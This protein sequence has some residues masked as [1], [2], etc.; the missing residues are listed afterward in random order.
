MDDEVETEELTYGDILQR[1]SEYQESETGLTEEVFAQ[2]ATLA[3]QVLTPEEIGAGFT[4][5]LANYAQDESWLKYLSADTDDEPPPSSGIE[6][7]G[8]DSDTSPEPVPVAQAAEEDYGKEVEPPTPKLAEADIKVPQEPKKVRLRYRAWDPVTRQFIEKDGGERILV[9]TGCQNP[10]R[11]SPYAVG[12][13]L[14]SALPRDKTEQANLFAAYQKAGLMH[15]GAMI[16]RMDEGVNKAEV[17]EGLREDTALVAAWTQAL[18]GQKE[19]PGGVA[20]SEGAPGS[21]NGAPL[22]P[23]PGPGRGHVKPGNTPKA[24]PNA[25]PGTGV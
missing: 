24:P 18:A 17:D 15:R 22:P 8:P 6:G 14:K 13:T 21:N 11:A 4:E 5:A 2:L 23:G 3:L 19:A 10:R 1:A 7:N 20:Q 9:P 16:E 25:R 12:V